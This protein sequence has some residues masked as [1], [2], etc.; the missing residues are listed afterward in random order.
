VLVEVATG[1]AVAAYWA[2]TG[3]PNLQFEIN[4]QFSSTNEPVFKLVSVSGN[5]PAWRRID[6]FAQNRATVGLVNRSR[7]TAHNPALRIDLVG[8]RG[9]KPVTG[10]DGVVHVRQVGLTA[11]QWDGGANYP[12]HGNWRRELPALVLDD[13]DLRL[14]GEVALVV[15]VVAD[16]FRRQTRL[17]V[18]ALEDADY[19]DY[20]EERAKFFEA[21]RRP[22]S[23]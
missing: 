20:T 7:H 15:T 6:P 21:Q 22:D 23:E 9:L 10:W 1:V 8:I 4:F 14:D 11:L 12:I 3:V 17:V 13:V 2:A 5:D 19:N 16:G 18:R